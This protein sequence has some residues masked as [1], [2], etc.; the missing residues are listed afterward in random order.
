MTGVTAEPGC[1]IDQVRLQ[2][3]DRNASSLRRRYLY[4]VG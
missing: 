4:A 1:F 2:D 3:T